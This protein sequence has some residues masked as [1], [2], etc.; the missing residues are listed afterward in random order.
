[1]RGLA[2]ACL[3]RVAE[4]VVVTNGADRAALAPRVP[5][6]RLHLVPIGS[7]IPDAPPREFDRARFREAAG[8]GADVALVAY[9]GFLNESKGAL[10][11]LDAVARLSGGG[12]RLQL[13]MIGGT[14]GASDPTNARYLAAFEAE[15][16]RRQL[17]GAVRWS[18][19]LSASG[20]SAWLCAADVIA[21][22]YRD[23]A[24]YRRGSLLAALEHGRPVVTTVP[25]AAAPRRPSDSATHPPQIGAKHGEP[26][27]ALP[28]LL[29]RQSAM[30]VAPDDARA[31]SGAIEE[32]L[33]DQ[34]LAARLALGARELAGAFSWDRIADAHIALYRGLV[35]MNAP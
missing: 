25:G 5:P 9:F 34:A 28:P 33:A 14:I 1:L 19:P 11:L 26:D 15:V 29:D 8:I 20:V 17:G 16:E 3:A 35:R 22:P 10:T 12:R 21:L 31:L 18:G 30:L 13:A 23:G 32:V 4:R 24:S 27:A 6:G 2:V 7:N